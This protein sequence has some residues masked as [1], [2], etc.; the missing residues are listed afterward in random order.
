MESEQRAMIGEKRDQG[1][2]NVMD[3]EAVL[4][5]E[6]RRGRVA[7]RLHFR[8]DHLQTMRLGKRRHASQ[9]LLQRSTE[10]GKK[11]QSGRRVSA[12]HSRGLG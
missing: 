8:R 11:G 7:G 2:G 6:R 4:A 5:T 12:G 9:H 10:T 1:V 3:R